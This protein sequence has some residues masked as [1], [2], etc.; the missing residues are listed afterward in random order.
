MEPLQLLVVVVEAAVVLARMAEEVD[1]V[2]R[3][4]VELVAQLRPMVLQE[5]RTGVEVVVVP[6]MVADLRL[7]A[8]AE[9]ES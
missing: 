7:V 3:V 1:R 6:V 8:L 5:P 4:S 9:A 2:R